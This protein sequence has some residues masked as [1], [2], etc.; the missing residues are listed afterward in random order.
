MPWRSCEA[1]PVRPENLTISVTPST[2]CKTPNAALTKGNDLKV[3]ASSTFDLV[4]P[5]ISKLVGSP[6][7]LTE[8][9]E[10]EIQ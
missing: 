6:I 3:T 10:V 1:R 9:V 2:T 5:I 8:S 4:T 7:T